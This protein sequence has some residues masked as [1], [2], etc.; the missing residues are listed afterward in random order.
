MV[1][2]VTENASQRVSLHSTNQQLICQTSFMM[3]NCILIPFYVTHIKL[4]LRGAA[5]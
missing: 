1:F 3:Q 2:V 4:A 5:R